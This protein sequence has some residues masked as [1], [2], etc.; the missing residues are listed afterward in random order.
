VTP[1]TGAQVAILAA[2]RDGPR[3]AQ[4][5]ASG[6]GIDTSAARRHLENLR[7]D[8]L[9]SASDSV[10]GPGRPKK[11]YALTDA[12]REAFPRDYALLLDL[13]LAKLAERRDRREVE[14]LMRLVAKDVAAGIEGSEAARI[15]ALVALYNRLGFDAS[16][17][18]AGAAYVLTQRNC[19][20]LKTARSDPHL[21]CQ[22]LDEGIIRAALPDARVVLESSLATGAPRCRHA[23]RMG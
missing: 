16:V 12:G 10:Q 7:E 5:V 14:S 15:K 20:F 23:I 2:L 17:E 13:V 3:Q 19:I 9:V 22:C 8:G 4:E 11:R 18:R 6:L 1:P 21:L